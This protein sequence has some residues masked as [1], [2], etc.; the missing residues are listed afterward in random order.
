[1]RY[2]CKM[3][4]WLNGFQLVEVSA[5]NHEAAARKAVREGQAPPGVFMV[6]VTKLDGSTSHQWVAVDEPEPP[7]SRPSHSWDRDRSDATCTHC[8]ATRSVSG[9]G[10][11]TYH[12]T[13]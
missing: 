9:W 13:P 6:E 3:D 4:L 10:Q 11:L 5:R 8:G 12:L 7:C 1:M 2:T